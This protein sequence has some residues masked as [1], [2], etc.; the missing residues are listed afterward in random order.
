[1][2]FSVLRISAIAATAV[3]PLV[4]AASVQAL[5]SRSASGRAPAP[6]VVSARGL[7]A[8]TLGTHRTVAESRLAKTFGAPAHA[9]RTATV[10]CKVTSITEWHNVT[11]FYAGRRFVGY[12]VRRRQGGVTVSGR[13]GCASVRASGVPGAHS[14]AASTARPR[15]AGRGVSARR[16]AG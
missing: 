4:C 13:N 6:V 12:E 14:A 5:P 16:A 10:D 8:A 1:V 2:N 15:K 9:F 3:V 11:A 7:A